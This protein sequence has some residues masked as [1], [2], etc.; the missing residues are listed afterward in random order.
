M[1][2]NMI[3]P[4][5]PESPEDALVRMVNQYQLPLLRMCCV[6]LRDRRLAEDAVQETFLKA[7]RSMNSFRGACSERSWLMRIAINTCCDMKRST[8]F[9]RVDRHVTPEDLPEG[10]FTPEEAPAVELADVISRLPEK[11]R[12]VILLYYY[13]DLTLAE[14]GDALGLAVSSVSDRLKK[15]REKL[16]SALGKEYLHE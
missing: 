16:R 8:W 9:R 7:Y 1:Q 6:Y 5:I 13:Q 2:P 10:A 4:T 12:Q 14:I 3:P 15:A 11:Y